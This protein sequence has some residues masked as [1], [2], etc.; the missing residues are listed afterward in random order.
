MMAV[1]GLIN[2]TGFVHAWRAQW[3][4]GAISIITFICTLAY[5]P[6]WT[7]AS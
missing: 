3:Y 7:R 2:V 6:T 5:A 1:V 4:D